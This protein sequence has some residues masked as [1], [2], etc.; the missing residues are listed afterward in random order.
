[1]A[2]GKHHVVEDKEKHKI[3]PKVLEGSALIM[4]D[5]RDVP[6]R[7]KALTL[8]T[9]NNASPKDKAQPPRVNFAHHQQKTTNSC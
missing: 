3:I 7:S 2:P 1:M 8:V 4:T 9:R 5:W 6:N